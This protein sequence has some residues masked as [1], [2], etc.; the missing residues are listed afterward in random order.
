MSDPG[1]GVTD[2]PAA[3]VQEAFRARDTATV[4][5]L[6]PRLPVAVAVADGQPRVARVEGRRVLPAFTSMASWEAFGSDDEVRLLPPEHFAALLESSGVDAVLFDP[7]LPSAVTV[8]LTEVRALLRGEYVDDRGAHLT[9]PTRFLPDPQT[10]DAV[11][12][13]L[14]S[15]EAAALDGRAWVLQRLGGAEPVPTV[16]LGADVEPSEVERLLA[17]LR[18]GHLP[19]NLEVTQ[20]DEQATRTA[21]SGWAEA[22]I[23]AGAGS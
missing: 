13:T 22:G 17:A 14:S 10:R 11:R 15:E 4:A 7:A 16:A 21:A 5:R 1:D 23:T 2:D 18:S 19:T 12:A 3:A 9:G 6:L 8:P 20:L